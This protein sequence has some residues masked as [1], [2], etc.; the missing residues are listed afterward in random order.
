[1]NHATALKVIFALTMLLSVMSVFRGTSFLQHQEISIFEALQPSKSWTSNLS[2]PVPGRAR[3]GHEI[4]ATFLDA[5]RNWN[6]DA[7]L[8]FKRHMLSKHDVG[9]ISWSDMVV[10]SSGNGPSELRAWLAELGVPILV[11]PEV[12]CKVKRKRLSFGSTSHALSKFHAWCMLQ[13]PQVVVMDPNSLVLGDLRGITS[14]CVQNVDACGG[15]VENLLPTQVM[16]DAVLVLTPSQEMCSSF[17]QTIERFIP[18]VENIGECGRDFL[19]KLVPAN[20]KSYF[21]SRFSGRV[22]DT[23]RA[24]SIAQTKVAVGLENFEQLGNEDDRAFLQDA[25]NDVDNRL[26]NFMSAARQ[27][28]AKRALYA[29]LLTPTP[30]HADGLHSLDLGVV[31]RHFLSMHINGRIPWSQM[32]IIYTGDDPHP[33]IR[34]WLRERGGVEIKVD[35]LLCDV[36]KA[37]DRRYMYQ[38]TKLQMW[39]L[40]DYDAIIYT[41]LDTF[42]V[43][44]ISDMWRKCDAGLIACGVDEVVRLPQR[45]YF[46]GGVFIAKPSHEAYRKLMQGRKRFPD[47]ALCEQD[48]LNDF[49]TAQGFGSL[50]SRYNNMAFLENQPLPHRQGLIVHYV[51]EFIDKLILGNTQAD[52]D[53][54]F[55][56]FDRFD[57]IADKVGHIR[58]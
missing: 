4:W 19:H 17:T 45:R 47:A 20:R 55:G 24:R 25:I 36:E 43:G 57:K 48:F 14:Q 40:T 44:D 1:M 54:L 58:Q 7:I 27:E 52:K 9:M 28:V 6:R 15:Q 42:I 21:D 49:L 46:N 5:S 38:F 22:H 34:K 10:L 30:P 51:P 56:E 2:M 16:D 53:F 12:Y 33:A 31:E 26:A 23:F 39:N 18:P 50:D 41:D 35:P 11:L 3:P 13:Y 8:A 37:R 29:T 32:G